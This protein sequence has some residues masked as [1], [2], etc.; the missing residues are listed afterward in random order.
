MSMMIIGIFLHTLFFLDSV[1]GTDPEKALLHQDCTEDCVKISGQLMTKGGQE[2]LPNVQLILKWDNT[3][4]F[5]EGVV[6]TKLTTRTD[7][8]GQYEFIF[9]PKDR[10]LSQGNFIIEYVVDPQQYLI[11]GEPAIELDQLNRGTSVRADYLIPRKSFIKWSV[12]QED[13]MTGSDYCTT[14][15]SFNMGFPDQCCDG[16]VVN[17][18]SGLPLDPVIEVA[19]GQPLF[20]KTLLVQGEQRIE[21][22]DTL[23]IQSGETRPYEIRVVP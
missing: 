9:N 10:E 3:N 21:Q 6:R 17:W 12:A 5:S 23:L 16:T 4:Y 19:G 2:P 13:Q 22:M 1:H 11:I 14:E 20:V 18:S 7:Q 15:F 8:D